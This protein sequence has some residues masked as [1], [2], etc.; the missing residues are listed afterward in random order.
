MKKV[1]LLILDG[2]GINESEIGDINSV[3]ICYRSLYDIDFF[4]FKYNIKHNC[5]GIC[6]CD[7]IL[8]LSFN[9]DKN[10]SSSSVISIE[11]IRS[12]SNFVI[13]DI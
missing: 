7:T 13:F 8:S 3:H 4:I 10:S 6:K 9:K 11:D 2:F 5:N 12:L 1:L